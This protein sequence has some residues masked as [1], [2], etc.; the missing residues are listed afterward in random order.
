MTKQ[1]GRCVQ[2][3]AVLALLALAGALSPAPAAAKWWSGEIRFKLGWPPITFEKETSGEDPEE[4]DRI[5]EA[6]LTRG[7]WEGAAPRVRAIAPGDAREHVE[8][9]LGLETHRVR[10]REGGTEPVRVADGYLG[11]LSTPRRMEFGYVIDH[12]AV[13]Q[14]T[15]HLDEAGRVVETEIFPTGRNE[16]LLAEPRLPGGAFGSPPVS[17]YAIDYQLGSVRSDS[18]LSR[19]GFERARPGLAR[20]EPGDTRLEV[21]RA[22]DGRHYVFGREAWFMANGLLPRESGRDGPA[23]RET[24]VFGWEEGARAIVKVRVILEEDVVRE[25]RFEKD[26]R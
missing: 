23:G 26:A 3:A 7:A 5:V 25:I 19:R 15:V 21:E 13:R 10:W 22:V 8:A 2:A 4:V 18:F 17:L 11:A 20:L 6:S 24:L 9:A 16:A 12:L 14:W 1:S